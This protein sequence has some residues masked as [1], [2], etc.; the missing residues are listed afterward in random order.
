MKIFVF[1]H[2]Q[3][4][5]DVEDR[6]G[7]DYDDHLTKKG[8][9]QAE[10]LAREMKDFGIEV[11]FV[12]SRIRAQETARILQEKLGVEM[13]TVKDLRERNLYGILTGMKKSEAREKYPDL[14]GRLKNTQDTID[15]AEPWKD[16]VDR[17][18]KSFRKI[19]KSEYKIVGIVTH[20][21][22][23]RRIL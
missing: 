7:G 13:K 17:I 6:Y 23:I 16:F 12:S 3:T 1:R 15:K 14:V 18:V 20:G 19:A 21:G 2:G 22:P 11:L 5:S 4:T 8:E 9:E 10:D